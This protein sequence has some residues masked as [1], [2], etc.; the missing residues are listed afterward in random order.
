MCFRVYFLYSCSTAIWIKLFLQPFGL[1][2]SI[3]PW[4]E[5]FCCC[6]NSFQ[7]LHFDFIFAYFSLSLIVF[8]LFIDFHI[9]FSFMKCSGTL[10]TR[11]L[12]FIIL[13]SPLFIICPKT[14]Y[15]PPI[16]L[17]YYMILY[18]NSSISL[19]IWSFPFSKDF[20]PVMPPHLFLPFS[21][22]HYFVYQILSYPS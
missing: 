17:H 18:F 12:V 13:F 9:I 19:I 14:T 5:A 4:I 10:E 11:K 22:P 8:H 21:P 16:F 20:P 2:I 3:S 6:R 1:S 15:F 7:K